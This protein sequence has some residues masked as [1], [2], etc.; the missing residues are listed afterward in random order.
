MLL[1]EQSYRDFHADLF[2]DTTGCETQLSAV[3]WLQ[4]HNAPVPRI[5]LDPAKRSAGESPIQVSD[6][7]ISLHLYK[8][9]ITT[10]CRILIPESSIVQKKMFYLCH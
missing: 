9:S 8:I 1:F 3:Q 10:L 5:S 4:G 6:T 2:P 7:Y